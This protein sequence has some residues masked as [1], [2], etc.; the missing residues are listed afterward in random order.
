MLED[1]NRFYVA[2]MR[3]RAEP[4]GSAAAEGE[5]LKDIFR[6]QLIELAV[7]DI[8]RLRLG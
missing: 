6:I 8:S 2:L 5:K 3:Q 4:A 7:D 1:V